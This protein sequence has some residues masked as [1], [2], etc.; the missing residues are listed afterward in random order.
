MCHSLSRRWRSDL[1]WRRCHQY[2]LCQGWW[3]ITETL[4]ISYMLKLPPLFAVSL[5]WTLH[6][7]SYNMNALVI[8]IHSWSQFLPL[9]CLYGNKWTFVIFC[10]LLDHFLERKLLPDYQCKSHDHDQPWADFVMAWLP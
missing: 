3:V 6:T 4:T 5:F 7:K 10:V 8:L 1:W 9:T 2:L